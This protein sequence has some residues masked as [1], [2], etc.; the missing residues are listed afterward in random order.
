MMLVLDLVLLALSLPVLFAASY[1]L[2]ATLL[3]ARSPVPEQ[4][5]PE[6][7]FRFVVPAHNE[8]AG[9]GA[10]VTS[11]LGVDYPAS[12]FEVVVV[13]DNCEDDTAERAR[14]AGAMV[15]ERKDEQQRGK[16]YA[17]L[18][19]F[20]NLPP[21]L[22]AVV[23]VDA[24]TLVSPNILRSFAARRDLG[25]VAVQADY[26]VRNPNAGWRTRLI[27]IAFGAF[28]IVRSRARERLGLSCGLRGN[29]MCFSAGLLAAVPHEAFSIVEDVEY[30]LRLGEAGYRVHYADDAHVYGE[31]VSTAAAAS[32]QRRR[33]EEG[34]KELVRRNGWRLL[35]LGFARKNWVLFDLA[36]D[37]L[38][39]PLSRI[40]VLSVIGACAAATLSVVHG[41]FAL[42]LASFGGCTFAVVAY[43]LRGWSVSG[44]GPRGLFD[45]AIAPAYVLW[46]ASL[47][48]RKTTR[49]TSTWVRTKREGQ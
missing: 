30:G 41:S 11:L 23:V 25:A 19:A 47:R 17:L 28:H 39:P 6:R 42:S 4:R 37:L 5:T 13:A 40:A 1:L 31:M 21:E 44:T 27:A 10:T 32:S 18:L 26:A 46:K 33:W 16:G 2:L 12:L 36:L 48:F 24:D 38:V 3:S 8:S 45:L 9:I 35:R 29:G 20:S 34:R 14:A 22:D 15:L 7:R 49:P 43:V